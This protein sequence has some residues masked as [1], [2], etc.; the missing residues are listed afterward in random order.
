[1]KPFKL[2]TVVD[3]PDSIFVSFSRE[4]APAPD[5]TPSHPYVVSC[6]MSN[7]TPNTRNEAGQR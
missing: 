4:K 3:F 1:M 7:L 5:K 6:S 2:T